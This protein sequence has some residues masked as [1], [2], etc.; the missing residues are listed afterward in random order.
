MRSPLDLEAQK[1][2]IV[3]T[4]LTYP[5]QESSSRHAEPA[6]RLPIEF[7]TLGIHV[8]TRVSET[9]GTDDEKRKRAVKGYSHQQLLRPSLD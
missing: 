5:I 8:E 4:S 7:R 9:G 2:D 6:T 1:R 3:D